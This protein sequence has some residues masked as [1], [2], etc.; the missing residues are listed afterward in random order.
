MENN[1][2]QP[3]MFFPYDPTNFW[4]ELRKVIQEEVRNNSI[5]LHGLVEQEQFLH[6]KEVA[7]MLRISLVTLT[8]WVKRGLPCHKYR[9]KVYFLIS[10]VMTY[11]TLAK[12]D[13]RS[14]VE[15]R[16]PRSRNYNSVRICQNG[17]I[18]KTG[19][20]NE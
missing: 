4:S 6:R 12:T 20:Q 2:Q 9:G 17:K 10:E 14:V 15:H 16:A 19:H 11:I 1:Q 7:R 8:D 18:P 3:Q 5:S 13:N